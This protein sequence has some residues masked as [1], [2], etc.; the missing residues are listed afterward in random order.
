MF[1]WKTRLIN[2]HDIN[3]YIVWEQWGCGGQT[4]AEEML[5]GYTGQVCRE[6]RMDIFMGLLGRVSERWHLDR[7]D[8]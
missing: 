5:E 2:Y 4:Q 6:L 7:T 3:K 8:I 1:K